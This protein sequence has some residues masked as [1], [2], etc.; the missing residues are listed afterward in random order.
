MSVVANRSLTAGDRRSRRFLAG[1]RVAIPLAVAGAF[2]TG[3][4]KGEKPYEITDV[5]E[6]KDAGPAA[7]ALSDSDRFRMGGHAD[8]GAQDDPNA[9]RPRFSWTTPQGWSESGGSQ[10]REMGWTVAARP[11]VECSFAMAGG[12]VLMNVNRWRGQMALPALD[13]QG[14]SSIE[15]RPFFG[16]AGS[17]VELSGTFTKGGMGGQ[18]KTIDGAKLLGLIVE[19]PATSA[20]LKLTGPAADVDAE[21]EH[22]FA[23]ATSIEMSKAP[24]PDVAAGPDVS[25]PDEPAAK[26]QFSWTVPDGWTKQGERPMRVATFASAKSPHAEVAVSVLTGTA[27]GTRA[28]LDRW[29]GQMGAKPLSDAE[30]S[31]LPR[32][33]ILDGTAVFIAVEGTWAGMGGG[34]GKAG[35]MFLGMVLER[36]SGSVFAKMIGPAD[37]VRGEQERFRAFCE[38]IRD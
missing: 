27:G 13:E 17:V 1:A 23:L 11:D 7:P 4:G 22:F 31:A 30:F 21:K 3:C 36:E 20:F 5:R 24:A 37:E 18:P 28:N 32:A 2:L 19:L 26:P 10:F 16:R 34:E 35:W 25:S 8:A 14:L 29:R 9:G 38:S 6:R 15:K 12:A 33:K